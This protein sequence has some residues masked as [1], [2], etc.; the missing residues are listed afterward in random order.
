MKNFVLFCFIL[1]LSNC[2]SQDAT[3]K[4]LDSLLNKFSNQKEIQKAETSK[5]IASYYKKKVN[6][7]K[8]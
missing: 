4:I 5:N 7:I 6:I 2:Y 3:D 8:L 1:F